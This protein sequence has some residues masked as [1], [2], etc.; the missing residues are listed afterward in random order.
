MLDA[1]TT[2]VDAMAKWVEA[3]DNDNFGEARN[4]ARHI[5]IYGNKLAIHPAF[6]ACVQRRHPDV[7][8]IQLFKLIGSLL[9]CVTEA[10]DEAVNGNAPEP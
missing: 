7:D 2:F 6:I 4:V 9:T 3:I 1:T 5:H 10:R 8:V